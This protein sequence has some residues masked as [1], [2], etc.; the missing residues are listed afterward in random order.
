[1][2]VL[3]DLLIQQKSLRYITPTTYPMIHS[4]PSY[5]DVVYL[6]SNPCFSFMI[7]VRAK[8]CYWFLCGFQEVDATIQTT[9]HMWAPSLAPRAACGVARDR[10]GRQ[11]HSSDH[12]LN[13]AQRNDSGAAL[14]EAGTVPVSFFLCG[15]KTQRRK[16]WYLVSRRTGESRSSKIRTGWTLGPGRTRPVILRGL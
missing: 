15:L 14:S 3:H 16:S 10:S 8:S 11:R 7:D 6:S 5:D 1:M 4:T 2:P 12:R 13:V 9:S